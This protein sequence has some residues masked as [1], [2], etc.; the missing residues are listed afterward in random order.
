[1]NNSAAISMTEPAYVKP[2]H[3]HIALSIIVKLMAYKAM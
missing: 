3:G 1:M 2:N